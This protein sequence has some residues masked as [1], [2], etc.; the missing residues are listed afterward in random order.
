MLQ[1]TPKHLLPASSRWLL[2]AC[3]ADTQW[4]DSLVFQTTNLDSF[5]LI[6]FSCT[7]HHVIFSL[8]EAWCGTFVCWMISA[9][10]AA[11]H[12]FIWLCPIS[13]REWMWL[14]RYVESCCCSNMRGV[15][16]R[17]F[18][19]GSGKKK[20][21]FQGRGNVIRANQVLQYTFRHM[22]CWHKHAAQY[23]C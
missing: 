18:L 2:A 12:D 9:E 15:N 13:V 16:I 10:I 17:N 19:Y 22:L 21:H 7:P 20:M 11:E 3:G 6:H 1:Q 4:Q 14:S 8:T 23:S 5:L